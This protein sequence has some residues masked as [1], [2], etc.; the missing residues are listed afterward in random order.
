MSSLQV[1]EN[2]GL[3]FE[4]FGNRLGAKK[5]G[6]LNLWTIYSMCNDS[7]LNYEFVFSSCLGLQYFRN[8]FVGYKINCFVT[9][10]KLSNYVQ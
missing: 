4:I 10:L 8:W 9:V 2:E 1:V 7:P 6:M 5:L 3:K